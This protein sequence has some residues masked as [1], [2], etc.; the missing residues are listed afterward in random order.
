MLLNLEAVLTE[1]VRIFTDPLIAAMVFWVLGDIVVERSGVINLALDGIITLIISITF[2]SIQHIGYVQGLGIAVATSIAFSALFMLLVNI[3]HA[4][5]VL[6]GL[7]LNIAFYGLSALIGLQLQTSP[8]LETIV[9]PHPAVLTIASLASVLL[10]WVFLYRSR[11]GMA[12]RACGFNPRAAEHLG[13]RVWRT[14]FLAGVVGYTLVAFGSY[15]YVAMYRGGWVQYTGRGFGFLSIA[16]AMTSIWHPLLAYPLTL[17]FGY[18]Y[19][20]LY[21]LQLLYG[22]P[23]DVINAIPY[24]ASLTAITVVY[25]TPLHKKLAFPRSLGEV[26]FREE[27]AT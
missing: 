21:S 7:A 4:P 14:R 2:V 22:V 26:Y 6:T 12:I 5:H 17:L 8:T 11:V 24:L 25:A 23:A 20:S 13:V 10:T 16:V 15:I 9:L 1:V 3:L 27:R 18:L 19:T